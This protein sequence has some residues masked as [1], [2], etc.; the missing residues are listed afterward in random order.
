V[1]LLERIIGNFPKDGAVNEGLEFDWCFCR[2]DQ[3]SIGHKSDKSSLS[4]VI[5]IVDLISELKLR[6]QALEIFYCASLDICHFHFHFHFHF[7]IILYLWESTLR[8]EPEDRYI[9]T[10]SAFD[11]TK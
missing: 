2:I 5:V 8:C 3:S 1:H 6:E 9:C 11:R 4:F 10:F 7:A